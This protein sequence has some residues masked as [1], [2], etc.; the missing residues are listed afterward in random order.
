M[1]I[2]FLFPYIL[3]LSLQSCSF[4]V[5]IL[6]RVIGKE[7]GVLILGAT[8]NLLEGR[9]IKK[10]D[11]AGL[12]EIF[13]EIRPFEDPTILV[14]KKDINLFIL[15]LK[16]LVKKRSTLLNLS[17]LPLTLMNQFILTQIIAR[18]L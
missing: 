12:F 14:T 13:S 7:T 10:T 16:T 17:Q 18:L 11:S 4:S 2:K 5:K 8:V 9:D 1:S 15:E 3:L 6:G